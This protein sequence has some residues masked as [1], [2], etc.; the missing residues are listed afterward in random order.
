MHARVKLPSLQID[1]LQFT[2]QRSARRKTMQITV[3]RSGDLVLCAPPEVDEAALRAF[4]L[5]K[6]FWI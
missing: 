1:D 6:R 2:L 4:V 5:E 3:E